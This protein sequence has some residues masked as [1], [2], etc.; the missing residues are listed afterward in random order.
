M[1]GGDDKY[2][3]SL[4][5]TMSFFSLTTCSRCHFHGRFIDKVAGGAFASTGN[6]KRALIYITAAKIRSARKW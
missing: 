3:K 1:R 5:I 4:K 2:R 6:H